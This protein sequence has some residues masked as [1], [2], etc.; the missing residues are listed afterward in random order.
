MKQGQVIYKAAHSNEQRY[1]SV[2]VETRES[3]LTSKDEVEVYTAVAGSI[4]QA[5]NEMK[6]ENFR[7]TVAEE[8]KQ[9]LWRYI[10]LFI[11]MLFL[12]ETFFANRKVD[13]KFGQKSE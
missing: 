9:K 11:I 6:I 2:N 7:N 1:F 4:N 3:D 12:F 5:K 10:L 8:K 13:V